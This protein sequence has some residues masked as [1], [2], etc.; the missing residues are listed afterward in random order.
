MIE[1]MSIERRKGQHWKKIS[2]LTLSNGES[3]I[4]AIL[5]FDG[6][7]VRP[8]ESA[9][10]ASQLPNSVVYACFKLQFLTKAGSQGQLIV[11]E[12]LLTGRLRQLVFRIP[13]PLFPYKGQPLG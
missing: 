13:P 3:K 6:P 7:S 9:C 5:K 4:S 10:G 8:C 12:V 11:S 1:T 2:G